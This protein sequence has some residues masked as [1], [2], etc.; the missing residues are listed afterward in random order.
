MKKLIMVL[1][2]AILAYGTTN[3]QSIS[4]GAKAGLNLANIVGDDV[5]S[6]NM[7]IAYHAG[8]VAEIGI[9]EKFAVQPELLFS[10]QGATDEDDLAGT[11]VNY[12]YILG[13]L[14]L[15]VLAKYYVTE[16]LSIQAG[17]QVGFNLMSDWKIDDTKT[18]VKDITNSVD[19][20][21]AVG[22]GFRTASGLFI[23]GRYNMGLT[24]IY[25]D[26][27]ANN[28]VIAIA[29]G[30]FFGGNSGGGGGF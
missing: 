19:V 14:N 22:V 11:T 15:P 27:K 28:A 12:D 13:Y 26:V 30:Y 17:P 1:S 8:A 24:E 3:A 6:L 21:V 16:G 7:K 23:Q 20:G 2:I 29:V 9:S 10:V 5:E 25:E 18:D 4:F